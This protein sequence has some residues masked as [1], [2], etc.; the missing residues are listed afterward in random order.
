M[1]YAITY[2]LDDT[3]ESVDT[4]LVETDAN[5]LD[6]PPEEIADIFEAYGIEPERAKALAH[7]DDYWFSR[8]AEDVDVDNTKGE[9]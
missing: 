7:D 6:M 9:L 3:W 5:P 8:N 2:A 4:L 1:K